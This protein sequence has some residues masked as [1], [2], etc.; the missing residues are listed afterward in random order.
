VNQFLTYSIRH[1]NHSNHK[2]IKWKN[3]LNI[4][5]N[6]LILTFYKIG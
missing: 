2:D 1:L 3:S 4:C 5:F 6:F